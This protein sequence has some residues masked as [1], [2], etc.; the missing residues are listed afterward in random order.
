MANILFRWFYAWPS[1]FHSSLCSNM[2]FS[3]DVNITY[4]RFSKNLCFIT[5][6]KTICLSLLNTRVAG[7]EQ[8]RWSMVLEQA[9]WLSFVIQRNL[10]AACWILE[11]PGSDKHLKN[12]LHLKRHVLCNSCGYVTPG[13]L[14]FCVQVRVHHRTGQY[15]NG[16]GVVSV[17]HP[18]CCFLNEGV[19]SAGHCPE[20]YEEAPTTPHMMDSY[21]LQWVITEK[22]L[23]CHG[24]KHQWLQW[25]HAFLNPIVI[26]FH[27]EQYVV[28]NV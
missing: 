20:L 25:K 28:G 11:G 27:K 4:K 15:H 21:E 12:Y 7:D 14:K 5:W 19:A 13:V 26:C 24:L 18:S 8:L 1:L 16:A 2:G 23:Y 10:K 22:T 6:K 3:F 9:L 17:F